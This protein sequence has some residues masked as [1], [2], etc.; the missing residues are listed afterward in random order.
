MEMMRIQE[1]CVEPGEQF[2]KAEGILY[3]AKEI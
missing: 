1:V 3:D 2:D